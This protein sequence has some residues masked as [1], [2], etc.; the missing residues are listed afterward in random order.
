MRQINEELARGVLKLATEGC[1]V[2]KTSRLL[3]TTR[4]TVYNILKFYRVPQEKIVSLDKLISTRLLYFC[5]DIELL[6]K[7]LAYEILSQKPEKIVVTNRL[8]KLIKKEKINKVVDILSKVN[9]KCN[10]EYS[11]N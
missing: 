1:S 9:V 4:K 7:R 6:S 2:T 8:Q 3:G 11:V 5:D 10:L